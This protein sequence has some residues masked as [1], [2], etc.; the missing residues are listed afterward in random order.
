MLFLVSEKAT[1]KLL[2][3]PDWDSVIQICDAIRQGDV[4]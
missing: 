3:D 2:L 1:S 4:Q